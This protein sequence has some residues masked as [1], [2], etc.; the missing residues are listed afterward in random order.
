MKQTLNYPLLFRDLS[1]HETFNVLNVYN[2]PERKNSNTKK[3]NKKQKILENIQKE[4]NKKLEKKDLENIQ[5]FL[6]CT[7]Y[8]QEHIRSIF[9]IINTQKGKNILKFNILKHAYKIQ[10]MN[11]LIDLY[12]EL[13]DH[14]SQFTNKKEL[15]F[16]EKIK[17]KCT[18][19]LD[20]SLELYQ[21]KFLGHSLPPLNYYNKSP[22]K[23]ENWQK[24]ALQLIDS[25]KSMI[26][27]APTGS[28]KTILM[29]YLVKEN[30][31][32]L[33]IVP[34]DPLA[35]QVCASFHRLGKKCALYTKTDR[36][37]IH[38]YDIMVTT[39]YIETNLELIYKQFDYCVYDE[40]HCLNYNNGGALERLIK[41]IPGNIIA[42][43]ATVINGIEIKNWLSN[44]KQSEV[45]LIHFKGRFISKQTHIF[46]NNRLM[47]FHKCSILDLKTIQSDDFKNTNLDLCPKDIA[48]LWLVIKGIFNKKQIH[49]I[50]PAV[51]FKQYKSHRITLEQSRKYE[52]ALKQFLIDQSYENKEKVSKVLA[53]FKDTIPDQSIK[54]NK[55]PLDKVFFTLK[56]KN[57]LPNIAFLSNSSNVLEYFKEFVYSIE[58]QIE[59][60]FPF[61]EKHQNFQKQLLDEFYFFKEKGEISLDKETA[62]KKNNKNNVDSSTIK[63]R[64]IDL[65]HKN[66]SD[67]ERK[68][69]DK[70]IEFYEN[71]KKIYINNPIVLQNY[72]QYY[73]DIYE[74]KHLKHIGKYAV[75]YK[76]NFANQNITEHEYIEIEKSIRNTLKLSVNLN[77]VFLKSLRYGIGIYLQNLPSSYLRFIQLYSSK[78]GIIFSDKTLSLGINMSFKSVCLIQHEN[79]E[80]SD[81]E[82][83]QMMGRPGRRNLTT[84]AHVIIVDADP[85]KILTSQMSKITGKKS[86]FPFSDCVN[87]QYLIE[88]K[89]NIYKNLLY[90]KVVLDKHC[91]LNDFVNVIKNTYFLKKDVLNYLWKSNFC[92][93]QA[94][95]MSMCFHNFVTEIQKKKDGKQIKRILYFLLIIHD[96]IIDTDEYTDKLVNHTHKH[97][98]DLEL[99][100]TYIYVK[101]YIDD[102]QLQFYT[103]LFPN[104]NK[105]NIN[106][107]IVDI[108]VKSY[109]FRKIVDKNKR[110]I[111]KEKFIN[112]SSI[113]ELYI[114]YCNNIGLVDIYNLC[115]KL[116]KN[117]N[118]I[119]LKDFIG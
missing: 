107:N 54:T 34:T 37:N 1:K 14:F 104:I 73:K 26:I 42:L 23:L 17:K 70:L 3:Q 102:L 33:F 24:K 38:N 48:D 67:F 76:F 85:V 51:F 5:D 46:H 79:N 116:Y 115:N 32:I 108:F 50:I 52:N 100:N 63:M 55:T 27:L 40:I 74:W 56:Q 28:G 21:L 11:M 9:K 78:L 58:K 110:H 86:I 29:D 15:K 105:E 65:L 2:K 35:R 19:K 7:D 10:N 103:W 93:Y 94:I 13:K 62:K 81:M 91:N 68:Q 61:F 72:E 80:F 16:L 98:V 92:I 109:Y 47:D 49:N 117:M 101:K 59:I 43:S 96:I 45:F 18:K 119:I 53:Y 99:E 87:T 25:K 12:I 4:K 20:I 111:V 71:E 113:L 97:Y 69:L 95:L 89:H 30:N 39:P 6:N 75:P 22:F 64:S 88:N 84:S 82:V 77:N 90:K 60:E 66:Q 83:F 106:E 112:I 8:S 118:E 57:M 31:S 41:L 36:Y 114:D 44:I